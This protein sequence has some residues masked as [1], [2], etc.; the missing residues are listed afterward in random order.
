M[1]NKLFGHKKPVEPIYPIESFT[2]GQIETDEGIGFININIGYRDYPNKKFY[3]WCAQLLIEFKDKNEKGH[4]TEKEAETLNELENKIGKFLRKKHTVHF[5][6]RVTRK[7]FRD[8]IYYL[9]QPKLDQTE[10]NI[11]F[12]EINSIRAVNF[13]LDKDE[14]WKIVAEF[15]K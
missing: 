13:H 11:F 10:T 9:D 2:V 4:P 7:G 14:D 8:L 15:L 3:P 5:I 6:G 12:D 1:F